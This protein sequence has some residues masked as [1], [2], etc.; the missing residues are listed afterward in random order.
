MRTPINIVFYTKPGCHLCEDTQEM[1]EIL[2][3]RH[4]LAVQ[5]ID[6]TRDAEL[7]SRYW[8]KI[9]VVQIGDTML[10]APIAGRALQAAV[11]RAEQAQR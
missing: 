9:P 6:I 3:T 11:L 7:Y 1:L 10:Q 2:S 5:A 4:Q 8:S